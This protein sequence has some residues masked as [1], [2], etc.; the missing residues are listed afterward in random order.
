MDGWID[1]SCKT[2]NTQYPLFCVSVTGPSFNMAAYLEA[3]EHVLAEEELNNIKFYREQMNT[4]PLHSA[5]LSFDSAGDSKESTRVPG[6]YEIREGGKI[7]YIGGNP[8]LSNIRDCLNAHFSGND[9]L[10]I[11]AYLN[12]S[13]R[14]KWSN[15]YVRW[16]TCSKP[17]EVAMF[18]LTDFKLRHGCYPQYNYPAYQS[19]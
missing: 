17:R 3:Y 13:A 8:Q 1:G 15:V 6:V 10:S 7:I 9:G 11:G 19:E 16:M 5:M 12:G 18:L 4:R 2:Y 14:N